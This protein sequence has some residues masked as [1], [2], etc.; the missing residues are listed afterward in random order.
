M[1]SAVPG[2]GLYFSAE[3]LQLARANRDQEPIRSAAPLLTR[4]FEDPLCTAHLAALRYLF[5]DDKESVASATALLL[6]ADLATQN[7]DDLAGCKRILGWLSVAAML[8]ALP[9]WQAIRDSLRAVDAQVRDM[10]EATDPL[11]QIWQGCLQLAAGIVLDHETLR[12]LGADKYRWA[13]EE[14]IHPEGFLKGIVDV[15]DKKDGYAAQVSGTCALALMAEMAEQVGMALWSSDNRGVT[16]V[17]ATVYSLY[18]YFYPEKWKWNDGLTMQQ[19]GAAMRNGGA[20][21]EIVNRRHPLRAVE[22]LFEEMRPFFDPLAGG[23]TTLT[24]GTAA[25]KKRR[26]RLL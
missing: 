6:E 24:H 20:F 15:P 21:I 2:G 22:H 1:R 9:A 25:P 16:P 7:C 12:E 5:D 8:R 18:Y 10:Q 26:W 11:V 13:V 17:T 3:Q 4:Q 14:I 19:A 23:L